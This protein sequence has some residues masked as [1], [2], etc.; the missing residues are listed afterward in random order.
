MATVNNIAELNAVLGLD[1]EEKQWENAMGL[2]EQT[3]KRLKEL[4]AEA[5]KGFKVP[6]IPLS[7][8][9]EAMNI[10][11]RRLKQGRINTLLATTDIN[12]AIS[13]IGLPGAPGMKADPDKTVASSGDR[14]VSTLKRI[15]VGFLGI[16]AI[17]GF[18][19]QGN[20]AIE[21]AS[22]IHDLSQ[23]TGIS[24]DALQEF[25]FA[26][27]QSGS[28]LEG[29]I[30]GTKRLN[31]AIEAAAKHGKGPVVDSL[32]K[33]GLTAKGVQAVIK[34]GG[35]D[36]GITLVSERLAGIKDPA[37]KSRIA[38]ALMGR[39]GQSLIPTLTDLAALREDARAL[40]GVVAEDDINN[41]EDFGD[42]MGRVKF[43]IGGI[44]D[45]MVAGLIPALKNI[46]DRMLDWMAKNREFIKE[47]ISA[48]VEGIT[49]ALNAMVTALQFVVDNSTEFLIALGAIATAATIAWV[50]TLGPIT[51]IILG[52]T[53]LIIAFR[54]IWQ[55]SK[56]LGAV[57]AFL[58][59][60]FL[61]PFIAVGLAIKELITNWDGVKAKVFSVGRAIA[62]FFTETLPGA[63]S[64]A[65]NA[66]G[67]A[68]KVTLDWIADLP[69]IKQLIAVMQWAAG[70]NSR[71][72]PGVTGASTQLTAQDMNNRILNG[73]IGAVSPSAVGGAGSTSVTIEGGI[74]ISSP[75]ADPKQVADAIKPAMRSFFDDEMRKAKK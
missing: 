59:A 56:L 28:S 8:E 34:E 11:T 10:I 65:W 3:E 52:V 54:K 19:H 5:N 43:A 20:E 15:A 12:K 38:I 14:I 36:A 63:I 60:P 7:D 64:S 41:M 39:A 50:A 21:A 73:D 68:I 58:M 17:R 18:A 46:T 42:Q 37:E 67:K 25:K 51:L 27:E 16:Q 66:M 55:W 23:S 61:A 13:T 33:L 44:K 2:I 70:V 74:T 75:S 26:A 72:I 29:L 31:V 40:G 69:V 35:L 22:K 62:D 57:F 6:K 47:N 24:T 45:E 71:P 1:T 53:A 4:A 32:K 49:V 48:A 9:Q 30:A